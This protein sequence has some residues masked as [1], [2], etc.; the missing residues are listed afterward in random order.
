MARPSWRRRSASC[1]PLPSGVLV[2]LV[3]ALKTLLT[4]F[5][6]LIKPTSSVPQLPRHNHSL[7]SSFKFLSNLG[8]FHQ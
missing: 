2:G 3:E 8:A 1:A 4:G 7:S 6:C 5:A